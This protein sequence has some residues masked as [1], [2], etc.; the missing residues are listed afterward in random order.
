[1][2][3]WSADEVVK[4]VATYAEIRARQSHLVSLERNAKARILPKYLRLIPSR[5]VMA[6]ET[7]SPYLVNI[8]GGPQRNKIGFVIEWMTGSR[9][10]GNKA[11]VVLSNGLPVTVAGPGTNLE[12]IGPPIDTTLDLLTVLLAMPEGSKSRGNDKPLPPRLARLRVKFKGMPGTV[13]RSGQNA[14]VV[15]DSQR[16]QTPPP[17]HLTNVRAEWLVNDDLVW[18][19]HT[20]PAPLRAPSENAKQS[21]SEK[22]GAGDGDDDE[23]DD[24]AKWEPSKETIGGD[25][26]DEDE[27][28]RVQDD[29]DDDASEATQRRL[30]ELDG[31]DD[32]VDEIAEDITDT[33]GPSGGR[34]GSRSLNARVVQDAK[35][36]VASLP[37]MKKFKRTVTKVNPKTSRVSEI[38]YF[39]N[40]SLANPLSHA[41]TVERHNGWRRVAI[42]CPH[43]FAPDYAPPVDVAS[44]KEEKG[45]KCPYCDKS[46]SVRL[47]GFTGGL[48]EYMSAN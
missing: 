3:S 5:D 6:R 19:D 12:P 11:R 38:K 43:V 14:V 46:S 30:A 33:V 4:W 44:R 26:E 42:I 35:E 27:N 41:P 39:M 29:K 8:I 16:S 9:G 47:S 31:D 22:S 45:L 18:F 40:I 20:V 1:M 10:K 7:P 13:S 15:L 25:E 34:V 28:E 37:V 2:R 32:T 48:T 17:V 23:V 21:M 36:L 24:P